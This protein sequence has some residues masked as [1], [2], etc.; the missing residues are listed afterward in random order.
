MEKNTVII[1]KKTAST[2]KILEINGDVIVPDIKPDIVNIINTN[3]IPYI[4]KEDISTGRV[5]LDGNIDTYVV[6]L[7]D[8]GET[9]SIQTTLTFSD[10]IEETTITEKSFSK[11]SISLEMIEAKVLNERKLSI[12]ASVRIKSEIFE[13]SQIE[14]T[15][16]FNEIEGVEKLKETLDIKSIIGSNRVKTSIKED[17]SV[18][19]SFSLAEI[20]K[21]DVEITNLENKISYNKVLA[22]ADA[23]IKVV[24]LSEDGRIGVTSSTIPVMSFID[25][26]KIT[27]THTCSVEYSIRNM[28]FKV[29][30]KEMH[31]I[32]CQIDFEVS[33]E[34]FETRTIDVIEDMYGIKN[35]VDFTR[36]DVEV[37]VSQKESVE[38]I[39]INE[40]VVVEDILNVCDVNCRPRI[41]NRTK[42]GNYFNCE[43]EM[44][45]SIYYE[46][47][48]RNGLNV[49]E[50]VLPFMMKT[51]SE[52]EFSFSIS[53][54]QFTVSNENVNCD[55]EILAK[56]DSDCLKR[57]TVIDDVST[58]ECEEDEEYKMFMYFVK[59][60]DTIWK[61]AKRF[62]VCVK[63]IIA[64]N[65]LENPDRIC[66]GD[67]LYIMR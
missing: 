28:L 27:D 43:C 17:I 24:F 36:R 21:T 38:R 15:S 50:V 44:A 3:G 62:K 8:S 22:K 64:L 2:T 47:D 34:A 40:R 49:K 37:Q 26:D 67:R 45:M 29:N 48:N 51:E 12:R 11:Q 39:S 54:K 60:G 41:V 14:I 61:I 13:Q 4:Y 10:S 63:D 42:S 53:K 25:I 46:A 9:R 33:C 18:D 35:N 7:S 66:V 52:E 57:I 6:Y 55:I 32:A 59:S 30:S 65:K 23:N 16:D 5:R 19:N 31:S 58:S 20:L 1:N 56:K